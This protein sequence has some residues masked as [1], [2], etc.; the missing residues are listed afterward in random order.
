M[1]PKR[2]ATGGGARGSK[3]AKTTEAATLKDAAAA[4]KAED[5]KHT[6]KKTHKVDDNCPLWNGKVRYQNNRHTMC[7]IAPIPYQAY[8]VLNSHMKIYHGST[9]LNISNY[10]SGRI[11]Y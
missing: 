3:K 5:K 7:S 6:G 9:L 8:Q 2:K 10:A 11:K 1:P 4:L